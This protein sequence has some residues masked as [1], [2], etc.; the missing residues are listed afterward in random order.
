MEASFYS[1]SAKACASLKKSLPLPR[2]QQRC[3]SKKRLSFSPSLPFLLSGAERSKEW[4]DPLLATIQDP[5]SFPFLCVLCEEG[6][7]APLNG[8]GRRRRPSFQVGSLNEKGEKGSWWLMQCFSTYSGNGGGRG[9]RGGG[10]NKH[11]HRQSQKVGVSTV[12]ILD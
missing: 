5:F 6:R 10:R 4:M 9:R 1:R 7:G 2:K 8:R 11:G 12:P 3:S